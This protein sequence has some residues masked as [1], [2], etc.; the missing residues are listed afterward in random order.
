MNRS[1]NNQ[2]IVRM[3]EISDIYTGNSINEEEKNKKYLSVISGYNYIGTKDIGFDQHIIYE[4]GIKIPKNESKFKVAPAGSTLLCI[5]GGSAGRKI[6]LTRQDVCFG[7]KLCAFVPKINHKFVFYFLQTE[8]FRRIFSLSK[9]GLIGGVS[10]NKLKEIEIP[11]PPLAEQ[12]R[13]VQKIEELFAE[14]DAGIENLK[15]VKNQIKLYRQSVLKNA[16]NQDCEK[17]FLKNYIAE[18]NYGT[19][20][21]TN[22]DKNG[23]PVL[24]MGDIQN[25]K[26]NFDNLKF[27]DTI[28][29]GKLI[30]KKGDLLFNRTNSSELV[31]K[32]AVF[33]AD[34][35]CSFASY[36]IKVRFDDTLNSDYVCF[37]I[38]SPYGRQWAR[39]QLTQQV[40]QANINGKKLQELQIPVP[41]LAEQERIVA[42]IETRFE[43]ADAMELAVQNALDTAEKLKQAI[44]KKAFRGELVPQNPNDEP[45]AVLLDRIRAARASE[46]QKSKRRKK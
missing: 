45:A 33:K 3:V 6:G 36:I 7:N 30:L 10:V 22:D 44:L 12:E 19:S 13:I 5:E 18:M 40:G 46:P 39:S 17:K 35:K 31:G 27:L 26:L 20:E 1:G 14:I 23:I 9:N 42:E 34:R 25:G 21:K 43:R 32:S 38:N 2:T 37:Y 15:I 8:S 16:F 11:L 28:K 4:N 41:S 24:R 29:D